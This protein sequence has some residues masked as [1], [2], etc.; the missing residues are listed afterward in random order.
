MML[1]C[2]MCNAAVDSVDFHIKRGSRGGFDCPAC[3]QMLHFSQPHAA[4][5]RSASLAISFAA[6]LVI[7]VRSPVKLAIAALLLWPIAQLMVNAYCA[8]WFKVSLK[9]WTPLPA[10]PLSF[11]NAIYHEVRRSS[12]VDRPYKVK[13]HMDDNRVTQA[14]EQ[15]C[16]NLQR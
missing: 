9:P 10:R 14:S 7:G 3:G 12:R 15:H 8:R 5:R 1:K 16:S 13:L 11:S 4:I 2:P 6:L